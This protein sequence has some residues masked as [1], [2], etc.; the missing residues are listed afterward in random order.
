MFS[1]PMELPETRAL[2]QEIDLAETL[3]YYC[4]TCGASY[5]SWGEYNAHRPCVVRQSPSQKGIEIFR[6]NGEQYKCTACLK[7]F[8]TL[9]GIKRH[10]RTNYHPRNKNPQILDLVSRTAFFVEKFTCP[11]SNEIFSD[12]CTFL[13][14]TLHE[15]KR[16]SP[17][18]VSLP[19]CQPEQVEEQIIR[20]SS[21]DKK[22]CKYMCMGCNNQFI[23]SQNAHRHVRLIHHSKNENCAIQDLR[24]KKLAIISHT[25]FSCENCAKKF[26]DNAHYQQH[27]KASTCAFKNYKVQTQ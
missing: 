22:E 8:V 3:A 14:H 18:D 5:D 25:E 13:K 9:E 21:L 27:I 4:F 23:Q 6:P 7:M 24:T 12:K 16:I 15:K 2:N 17:S 1:I 10:V 11:D 19:H 20:D 26:Y